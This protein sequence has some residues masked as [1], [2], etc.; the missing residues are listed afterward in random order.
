MRSE[1]S[2]NALRTLDARAPESEEPS[3]RDPVTGLRDRAWFEVQLGHWFGDPRERRM[4][5]SLILAD[6]DG[7]DAINQ[8]YGRPAGDEVLSSVSA[9]LQQRLRGRDLLARFADSAFTVLLLR[10]PVATARAVAER[11]RA[12]VANASHGPSGSS[13]G[14]LR[15]TLSVGCVTL[16]A[17]GA[18]EGFATRQQVIDAASRALAAAKRGGCDRVVSLVD[19]TGE[20]LD[21]SAPSV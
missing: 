9:C 11:L 5:L 14:P 1:R 19:A 15:V 7:F 20:S 2:T 3:R 17:G 6:V 21:S 16:E 10:A 12:G 8:T 18:L 4:P 13:P